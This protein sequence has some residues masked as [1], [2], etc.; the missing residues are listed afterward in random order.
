MAKAEYYLHGDFD[1]ILAKVNAA[2]ADN[3]S[4]TLDAESDFRTDTAR[5]SVRIYE[6]RCFFGATFQ[7]YSA[8]VIFTLAESEGKIAATLAAADDDC[9]DVLRYAKNALAEFAGGFW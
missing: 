5:F 9:A 8:L 1:V 2:I 7:R 6:K 3:S 4:A